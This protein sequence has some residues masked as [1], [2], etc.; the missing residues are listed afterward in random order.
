MPLPEF[1]RRFSLVLLVCAGSAAAQEMSASFL[2]RITEF[3][4]SKYSCT[5]LAQDGRLRREVR[6]IDRR[7]PSR[8]DVPEGAASEDDVNHAKALIGDPDFQNATHHNPPGLTMVPP[9]GRFLTVEV[10]LDN[11]PQ[12]VIFADRNGGTVAPSYLVGFLSF[13][14]DVR[15]RNMPKIHGKVETMC[16]R[17]SEH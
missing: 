5:V 1:S 4:S 3:G 17:L 7:S 12:T 11:K 14:D 2:I 9:E 6:S 8:P 16:R 13:A 10:N 15:R